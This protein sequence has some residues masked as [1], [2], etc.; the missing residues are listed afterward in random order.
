MFGLILN[1]FVIDTL[2]DDLEYGINPN[3]FDASNLHFTVFVSDV[4]KK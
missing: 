2:L 4:S 1:W 3:C